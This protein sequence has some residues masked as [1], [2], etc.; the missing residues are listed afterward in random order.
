MLQYTPDIVFSSNIDC[1]FPELSRH[2]IKVLFYFFFN[3]LYKETRYREGSIS[4]ST[5]TRRTRSGRSGR[6]DVSTTARVWTD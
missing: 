2:F 5:R 1:Y 3:S 6:M 4:V